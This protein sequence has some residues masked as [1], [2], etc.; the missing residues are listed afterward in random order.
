MCN[1]AGLYYVVCADFGKLQDST[2]DS[3]KKIV[4]MHYDEVNGESNCGLIT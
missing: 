2:A 3:F 1:K 4:T